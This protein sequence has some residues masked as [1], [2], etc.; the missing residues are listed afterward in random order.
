[1]QIR[2]LELRAKVVVE[3]FWSGLH[4]SP[5]H[6]FSVEFTEYRE[7]SPG[8]DLRYLDW[9]LFARS[10]RYYVKR[11]EDETNLRCHL[12]LDASRSMGYGSIG[13]PKSDYAATLAATLAYFLARQRDAVGLV[14]FDKDIVEYLPARHRPRH[15]RRLLSMLEQTPAGSATDLTVPLGRVAELMKKRGLLVLISD[16]LAP[17][18]TLERDLA[19][20]R[21]RGHDVLLFQV[22]DPGEV[23]FGFEEAVLFHDVESR[24]E[25]YVDP[26]AVRRQY[27]DRLEK[28]NAAIES[29]CRQLGID[30]RRMLTNRPIEPALAELFRIRQRQGQTI[31]RIGRKFGRS[32]V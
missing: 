2:G 20:F 22:L 1:M 3:G 9:K 27:L 5:Y 24:R 14:T 23:E 7:Y 11:F 28:H 31:S 15:S 30:F 6:G 21:S 16:L 26:K 19:L 8:D 12:L 10:D 32:E 29:T 17:I 18:D 4:R 25:L 13:Y